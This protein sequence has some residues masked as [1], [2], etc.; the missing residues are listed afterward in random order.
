VGQDEVKLPAI[1]KRIR[2]QPQP[3]NYRVA[4]EELGDIKQQNGANP[5]HP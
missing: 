4:Q 5:L 3:E 1:V 2:Y